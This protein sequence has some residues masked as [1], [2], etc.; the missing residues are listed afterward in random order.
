MGNIFWEAW[1]WL[2][3][4]GAIKKTKCKRVVADVAL[5]LQE[6]IAVRKANRIQCLYLTMAKKATAAPTNHTK[7]IYTKYWVAFVG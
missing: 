6:K 7:D 1:R 5:A 3:L 4:P 2:Q